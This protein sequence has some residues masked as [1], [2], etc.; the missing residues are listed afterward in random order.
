[1][2]HGICG[3]C[4]LDK[5]LTTHHVKDVN[6]DFTGET[7]RVCRDCHDIIEKQYAEEGRIKPFKG[8]NNNSRLTKLPSDFRSDVLPYF[9]YAVNGY[10]MS[11]NDS[12]P[13]ESIE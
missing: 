7:Q 13:K 5:N 9:S 10:S 4:S 8:R 12:S 2:R 6:G 3:K 1:M 11:I